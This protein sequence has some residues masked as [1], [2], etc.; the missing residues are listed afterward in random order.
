MYHIHK[1][2]AVFTLGVIIPDDRMLQRGSDTPLAAF[3]RNT[4][5]SPLTAHMSI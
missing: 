1:A 5:S 2:E 4:M 3:N